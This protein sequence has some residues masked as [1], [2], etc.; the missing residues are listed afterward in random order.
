MED[1]KVIAASVK[2]L[3]SSLS[4]VGVK[5][6]IATGAV[7]FGL[8]VE[9][10][11]DAKKAFF[12]LVNC[13]RFRRLSDWNALERH[14]RTAVIGGL[15]IT[16]GVGAELWYEHRTNIL[17]GRLETENGL[18]IAN[19]NDKASASDE[20]AKKLENSTQQLRTDADTQRG[21]AAGALQK[22]AEANLIAEAEKL[23]RVELEAS[24]AWRRLSNR[25]EAEMSRELQ[26]RNLASEPVTVVFFG[27][28]AEGANFAV[29]ITEMLRASGLP[30]FPPRPLDTPGPSKS[31]VRTTDS[32]VRYIT[33]V[34]IAGT[35]DD[36]SRE[37]A[38]GIKETLE[39]HGFD[40]QII[41]SDAP[42]AFAK[43]IGPNVIV[44]ISPRPDGPQGEYK[45]KAGRHTQTKREAITSK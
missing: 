22:A 7:V 40:A 8:V 36:P 27:G 42:A 34:Q 3:E 6:A 15:F 18:L 43:D 38:K 16:V 10:W 14:V 2:S 19:L 5:L 30:A 35:D 32:I 11:D 20:R 45:L 9:Y 12:A 33:G 24:V 23:A 44:G 25:Q 1:P 26:K 29:D 4:L 31:A 28:S 13:I 21:I 39:D 17:E 37:L 41:E